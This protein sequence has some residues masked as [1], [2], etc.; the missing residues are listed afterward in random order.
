MESL[1]E[2]YDIVVVGAS[3][4]GTA[5]AIAA[6]R[7]G[8]R[9]ALIEES[10]TLG[11]IMSNGLS[12]TDGNPAECT[13]IYEE[14]RARCMDYYLRAAQD[15]PS[16]RSYPRDL[17]GHRYEPHVAHRIFSE[18]VAEI[19]TVTVFYKRY[20]TSVVMEGQAVVAVSTR[21]VEDAN[22]MVFE[23]LIFIDG[24]PEGDLLPLA[25]AEFRVGR[26]PR[27][28]EEPHAGEIYMTKQG[29]VFGSGSGDSKLQAYAMLLTIK[30]YGPGADKT[31][32]QPPRYDARNYCPEERSDTWWAGGPLPNG[33]FQ[34]NEN[35]DGTDFAEINWD[36]VDASR[37]GRKRIW[38]HYRDL[39]LGYLYFRQTVMGE[40]QL[41][42]TEDE[43]PENGHFPYQLYVREGRRLEGVHMFNERDCIRV[44]GFLRPPLQRH[45]IASGAWPI[46]SHA[47]TRDTEGYVYL[48]LEDKFKIS[49]PHQVPYEV[50]VPKSVDGLL[51]P[52]AVSA[53]HIGFQ[54]LRLEPIRVAMGQAAGLA[55]AMCVQNNIRPRD[56]DVGALQRLLLEK[57][58]SLFLYTDVT[59]TTPQF[60]AIQRVGMAGLDAGY[61]DFTFRPERNASY[62]DASK[63]LFL[64][65]KL[66]PKL[67][68]SDMW[69]IMHWQKR[70]VPRVQHCTPWESATY[71][72][73]T[74]N[75]AGAFSD[76]VLKTMIPSAEITRKEL[77]EWAGC[78]VGVGESS[79]NLL[80]GNHH[81]PGDFLSRGELAA[82]VV[83][84][85]T[86]HS[87][88]DE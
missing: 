36:W 8:M 43:Y 58:Q 69:K 18:M 65:L 30:D 23:A 14:F 49:A 75:N 48:G 57:G 55:A 40:R 28:P 33:K 22:A 62:S 13:G 67:D 63:L 42:L 5:A 29:E 4:G 53:T 51:V 61:D 44:P 38:E 60:E 2:S 87:I 64:G 7:Q 66:T 71:Y 9:V 11:G 6:G 54:V 50:M 41:G 52:M 3:S 76:A 17:L 86:E 79:R 31:L 72:L 32:S 81:Q 83:A 24:T 16:I 47:V 10:P 77:L 12:R 34:L 20:P 46:D 59:P 21:D 19:P 70:P 88:P 15:D 1:K 45:S 26:E 27:T 84:L 73:L 85:R 74:L 68:V 78:L 80:T 37:E 39:T 82:F 25:K 35:M 56:V